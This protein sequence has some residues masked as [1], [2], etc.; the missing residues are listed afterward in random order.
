[1]T[2]TDSRHT[3]PSRRRSITSLEMICFCPTSW[4]KDQTIPVPGR[5][6]SVA[7][8]KCSPGCHG[9]GLPWPV[10]AQ[11]R[12]LGLGSYRNLHPLV[13]LVRP[14]C[15]ICSPHVPRKVMDT[16]RSARSRKWV[17]SESKRKYLTLALTAHIWYYLQYFTFN[18][19]WHND[20][21]SFSQT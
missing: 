19:V 6:N 15:R 8:S 2:F 3:P 12:R 10:F 7:L 18:V 5:H 13:L 4:R 9:L 21:H 1:M 17:G 11:I 14:L 20:T 16:Q